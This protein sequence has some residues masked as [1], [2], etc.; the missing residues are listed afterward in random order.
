MHMSETLVSAEAKAMVGQITAGPVTVEITAREAQRYAQ[1]VDDLNPV[2][3]DET[4]A[5]AAGH[6]GLVIPPTFLEHAMVQG[7][8]VD[9]MRPDGLFDSPSGGGL[10]RRRVMFG[11]QE[12][13]WLSP[14]Y[15]GD[16]ITAV[17]RLGD[18]TEKS[19]SKGPFVLITWET[20]YTNQRGE[21]VALSR[22][23]GISR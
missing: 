6:P 1:A 12:W 21:T 8:S 23:Q 14:V 3:F 4:A 2:Y 22:E 18:I 7:R 10:E 9:T 5:R 13:Q 19:G 17:Q 16:T 20:T 15:V 11:G